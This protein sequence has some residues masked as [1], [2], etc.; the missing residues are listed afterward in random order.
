MAPEHRLSQPAYSE[1][2]TQAVFSKLASDA[3]TAAAAGQCVIADATFIATEHR[4]VVED[5]AR[6]AGVPFVG[7][8]LTAAYDEL[9]RRILGRTGDA[10]D[11]TLAVL[12]AA[13]RSEPDAGTWHVIHSQAGA[14]DLRLAQALLHAHIAMC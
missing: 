10:S 5:A 8:W 11:A 12:R 6:S 3:A 7:L 14:E 4:H 13:V 2:A 9:E 1:A